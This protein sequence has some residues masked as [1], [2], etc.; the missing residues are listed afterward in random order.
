MLARIIEPE[1]KQGSLRVLERRELTRRRIL[2]S[3]ADCRCMRRRRGSS[4]CSRRAPPMPRWA[5]RP[6]CFYGVST[7]YFE[8]GQGDGF[9]GAG[10]LQ[11]TPSGP[12]DHHR[13]AHRRSRVPLMVQALEGNKAETKTMLPG[14]HLVHGRPMSPSSRTRIVSAN[15]QI[16][17]L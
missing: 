16:L 8:T 10:V 7:L 11:A 14:H 5:Q 3:T 12:A 15:S 17:G 4:S 9:R 1:S 13:A 6:W 2:R